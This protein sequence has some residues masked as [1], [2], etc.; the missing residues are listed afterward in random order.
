MAPLTRFRAP[1]HLVG[2]LQATYYGQRAS[3]GGLL[4][5]EAT[6]IAEEAGGFPA[7]PGIYT[8]SQVEAWKKVTESVHAK[9]GIIYLQLWAIG[10]ANP[11]NGDV[12]KIVSASDLKYEGG[13]TPTPMTKEDIKR[14]VGHYRQAALNAVEAGFDGVEIHSWVHSN[15]LFQ[16]ASWQSEASDLLGQITRSTFSMKMQGMSF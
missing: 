5:S 8:S 11:G 15:L 14:Y 7:A 9:G 2:D 10:R 6:F 4:I 1:D 16:H 13:E 3:K 12:S